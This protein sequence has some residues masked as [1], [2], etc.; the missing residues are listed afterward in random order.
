M[1]YPDDFP[2]PALYK[3]RDHYYAIRDET[4]YRLWG[5]VPYGGREATVVS[6]PDLIAQLDQAAVEVTGRG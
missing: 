6:E 2:N 3:Y 5:W 4:W 1:L